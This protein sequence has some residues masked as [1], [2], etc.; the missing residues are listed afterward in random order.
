MECDITGYAL[1]FGEF[2]LGA[3]VGVLRALGLPSGTGEILEFDT[4]RQY[5]S[6]RVCW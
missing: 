4:V 5:L 2:Q 3:M 1:P 6:V